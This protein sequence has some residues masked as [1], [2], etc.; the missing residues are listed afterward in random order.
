MPFSED[1]L[2]RIPSVSRESAALFRENGSRLIDLVDRRMS[3]LHEK[4]ALFG[5]HPMQT[6]HSQ[7]RHH[8]DMIC[9]VLRYKAFCALTTLLPWIYRSGNSHGIRYAYFFHEWG[10]WAQAVEKIL[11][12]RAAREIAALYHWMQEQHETVKEASQ[13]TPPLPDPSG[14]SLLELKSEQNAFLSAILSGNRS[15]AFKL[16]TDLLTEGVLVSDIFVSVIQRS[17]YEVGRL[18]ETGKISVAKEHLATAVVTRIMSSMEVE[19]KPDQPSR[20]RVIVTAAPNEFHELGPWMVADSLE[21]DGWDVRYLG[22]NTPT[23]DLVALTRE[24]DPDIIA[25]SVALASHLLFM[26]DVIRSL[27]RMTSK[28]KPKI[29][30]G[31]LGFQMFPDLWKKMGADGYTTDCKAAV[32]LCRLWRE[33]A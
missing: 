16:V 33:G 25:I 28:D 26:E 10:A 2:S 13:T 11:P 17:L 8:F 1:V 32:R 12:E 19:V 29:M 3:Q 5:N 4:E 15:T 30:V 31:G 23:Q 14:A 18:W 22:A 20:G 21:M 24:F 6:M 7:H 27:R 9:V